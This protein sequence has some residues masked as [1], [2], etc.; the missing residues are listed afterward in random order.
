MAPI[1]E[2]ELREELERRRL[3]LQE[4]IAGGGE[5]GRLAVLLQEIDAA[6]ARFQ[7]GTYGLCDVCHDPVEV[8]R[9]LG[10]P[11]L[12]TCLDHL[13]SDERRALEHDLDLAGRVQRGL[14]PPPTLRHAGWE[15]FYHYEPAGPVG[16][17]YCD[18]IPA[19]GDGGDLYFVLGDVSGKGLSASMLMSALRATVRTLITASP[20]VRTLMERSNRLFCEGAAPNHFATL[21]CGR[22][23]RSGRVEIANA[24]HLPPLLSRRGG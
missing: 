7:A 21:V 18:L 14:L 13:T 4:T 2:Q 6:L 10:D 8:E 12:H 3:R 20:D 17:D 15:A 23:E 1:A 24:G 16:G 11:L 19:E 22:A 5:S 9:L